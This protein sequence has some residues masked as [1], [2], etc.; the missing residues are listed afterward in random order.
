MM[1]CVADMGDKHVRENREKNRLLKKPHL[2]SLFTSQLKVTTAKY[3][4]LNIN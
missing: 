3:S 1:G 2:F 4:Q